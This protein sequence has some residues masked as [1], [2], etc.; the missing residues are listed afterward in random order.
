MDVRVG[1]VRQSAPPPATSPTPPDEGWRGGGVEG[2]R[3]G[4]VE[5]WR[6]GGVEGWMVKRGG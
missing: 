4:G 2:W 3:G 1:C 5:G 6:G